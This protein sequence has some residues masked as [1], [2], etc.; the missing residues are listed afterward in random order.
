MIR[1]SALMRHVRESPTAL[2]AQ[3]Q[4]ALQDRGIAV[5]TVPQSVKAT[6]WLPLMA[7]MFCC[8]AATI[9]FFRNHAFER[10]KHQ[11]EGNKAM[12]QQCMNMNVNGLT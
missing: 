3:P 4:H 2:C 7:S 6:Q 8:V 9:L 10:Q 5:V 11:T 1:A 12:L